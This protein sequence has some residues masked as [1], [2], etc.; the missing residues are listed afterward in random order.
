[1]AISEACQVWIEQRVEE[2][3]ESQKET[4]KSLRAIGREIAKE[5]EKIFETKVEPQTI[6]T[7]A[8]RQKKA[9]SNE[10]PTVTL[11]DHEGKEENQSWKAGRYF[12]KKGGI[13]AKDKC[14]CLFCNS[15]CPNCGSIDVSVDFKVKYHYD[16]DSL[17]SISILNEGIY[18]ELTCNECGEI[19]SYGEIDF[20]QGNDERLQSLHVALDRYFVSHLKQIMIDHENEIT[21]EEYR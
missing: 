8:F 18:I 19:F 21:V 9:V 15:K 10:T 7:K 14:D 17:D 4:G 20:D 5:I 16:N 12:Q 6:T 3:L 13:M 1:M 11:Q 2:E